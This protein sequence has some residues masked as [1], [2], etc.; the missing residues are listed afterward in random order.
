LVEDKLEKSDEF[1]SMRQTPSY[2]SDEGGKKLVHEEGIASD[3]AKYRNYETLRRTFREYYFR[4]DKRIE[5]PREI[6]QREFGFRYFVP[7]GELGKM[8][9]HLTF[10]NEGEVLA[11]ALRETPSDLY[12][13]N[14]YYKYPSYQMQEK[15]WLG[16]DLIFDI[17]AKDLLLPCQASH[18]YLICETCLHAIKGGRQGSDRCQLCSSQNVVVESIPCRVCIDGTKKEVQK[19]VNVLIDDFGINNESIQIYFS[20]NEGFHLYVTDSH[21]LNLDAQARSDISGYILGKGLMPETI[22]V[23]RRPVNIVGKKRVKTIHSTERILDRTLQGRNFFSANP[24]K[25]NKINDQNDF[26]IKLSKDGLKYGWQ[27]R[28]LQK[29]EIKNYSEVRLRNIVQ[30]K[31]GYYGFKSELDEIGKELGINIDPQVTMDVHRI[32]RLPGTL[33]SKSGLAKIKCSDLHSFDPLSEACLLGD[34]M[35]KIRSTTSIKL[36]LKENEFY[37]DENTTTSLPAYAAIYLV[38]KRLAAVAGA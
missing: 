4:H 26:L 13:S 32:F 2:G 7:N 18:S 37:V 35:I 8:I 33:N 10:K 9:R 12:C 15:E 14:A 20:G 25:V 34:D 6:D 27:K 30:Q 36:I 16:A 28:L 23:Y 31:R 24:N 5:C 21:F 29:L 11:A 1:Q 22:G 3:I 38:C 17:D 19:L